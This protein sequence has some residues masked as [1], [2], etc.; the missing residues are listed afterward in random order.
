MK[1][2]MLDY[3]KIVLFKVSFCRKLFLKEYRKARK[4]LTDPEGVELRKWIKDYKHQ[5]TQS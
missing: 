1:T 2:T 5:T 3:C 4:R